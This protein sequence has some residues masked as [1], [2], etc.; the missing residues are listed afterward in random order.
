MVKIKV[1]QVSLLLLKK[2]L[3][4]IFMGSIDSLE[5]TDEEYEIKK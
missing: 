1:V 2:L 3:H 4:V 5:D